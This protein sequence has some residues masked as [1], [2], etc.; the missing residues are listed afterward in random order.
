MDTMRSV[1]P[2]K[3]LGQHFLR[4]MEVAARI[5]DTVDACPGIPLLEVGAGTGVL[6]RLLAT[7]GRELRVVEIDYE[8]VAYLL[9]AFPALEEGILEDDFLTLRLDRVFDG[10][11]FVLTGNYPYNISSQ[12]L[13]HALA[14]RELIPCLTGML[15]REVAERLAA[16]PGCKAYGILSVLMQAW[17]DV[18][19]LFTVPPTAF[20]PP[21]KVT[22]AVVRLTRNG[23][24]ELGCDEERFRHVVK[25][26]FNQRRKTLRNA[27]SPLVGETSHADLSFLPE[28]TLTKRAEQLS[29][30]QFVEL[31]NQIYQP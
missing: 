23:V 12:I 27:L 9:R 14:Y 19:L 30:E 25:T 20:Q 18:E 10:R 28:A 1:R 8:S 26:A 11:P 3:S 29:V 24:R 31:T 16:K 13:F 22:S 21:P 6:T 5:A 2:K 4:D 15:Q 7:K 17:Y